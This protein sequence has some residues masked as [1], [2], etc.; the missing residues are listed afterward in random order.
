MIILRVV[1]LS[2]ISVILVSCSGNSTVAPVTSRSS[3]TSQPTIVVSGKSG[4]Y[5]VQKGDTLY[6]IAWQHGHDYKT[7]ARWNEIRPPYRLFAGQKLRL[8]PPA[9]KAARAEKQ[10]TIPDKKQVKNTNKKTDTAAKQ[11]RTYSKSAKL[12]WH[13]PVDGKI[14]QRYSSRQPG[15]KG[16]VFG[17]KSGQPVYATTNGK[18]VY[19][20]SG[21][22]GYGK[23]II[24]KHNEKFLSAY[25]HNKTLLVKEGDRV[26]SGQRI[27]EMGQSG[28]DRV[29]LHFEIR[30][31]GRP[32]NP[33][34][35]LPKQKS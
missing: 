10:V 3:E 30:R 18:V 13:W 16:I 29:M 9:Q 24:I 15:K 2:L 25:G 26:K 20:G 31:D 14:I 22:V 21:L 23:L 1:L 19:S 7:V 17:G 32:V 6:S 34:L 35:Y 4:Q 27:A 5:I 33:L 28:A 11:E 8:T 12:V